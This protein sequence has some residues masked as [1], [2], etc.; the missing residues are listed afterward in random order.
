MVK[1]VKPPLPPDAIGKGSRS[2][3]EF[4]EENSDTESEEVADILSWL[5]EKVPKHD[6]PAKSKNRLEDLINAGLEL[7]EMNNVTAISTL[8]KSENKGTVVERLVDVFK[9]IYYAGKD[10]VSS[11]RVKTSLTIIGG[12]GL[13]ALIGAAI[14][15]VIPIVG[16]AIGGAV[17]AAIAGGVAAVGGVAGLTVLGAFAGSW[18]GKRAAGKAF[19]HEKRFEI[20]K[21]VT[22]KIKKHIGIQSHVVQMINGYLYNRVEA[23]K[24]PLCKKYYNMVRR[25]AILE[26]DPTAMEKVSRFFCHELDLLEQEIEMKGKEASNELRMDK[27]AVIYILEKLQAC[28]GLSLQSKNKI[29]KAFEIAK[30]EP[31]IRED[32]KAVRFE[33]KQAVRPRLKEE[34][35]QDALHKAKSQ[36]VSQ[37]PQLGISKTNSVN[38]KSEKGT[39]SYHYQFKTEK[40]EALPEMVFRRKGE[41]NSY[42]TSVTV[43]ADQLTN[44]NKDQVTKVIVAQ[45]KAYQ[46]STGID[47]VVVMAAGDDDLAVQL[48]VAVL[49]AGL[50]PS[51]DPKEYPQDSPKRK[52]ILEAVEALTQTQAPSAKSRKSLDF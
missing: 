28:A 29:K 15:S 13:G 17:G 39:V 48:M 33:D 12:I 40:G 47:E 3:D 37:L 50:K 10:I 52:Q 1:P 31:Q 5:E 14:G 27:Q 7:E 21:R 43:K 45:A 18:L 36:F 38:K 51:L 6:V 41:R 2:F 25:L 19:K 44:K 42:L 16:T 30:H 9:D 35:S 11:N 20:S 32:K 46:E 4:S 23:T 8:K 34:A 22:K 24:S 49:E 26:A